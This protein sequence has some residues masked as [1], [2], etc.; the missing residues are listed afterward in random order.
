MVTSG[1]GLS[2]ARTQWGITRP[3]GHTRVGGGFFIHEVHYSEKAVSLKCLMVC[4]TVAL[5]HSP[6][7]L[8]PDHDWVESPS[9]G[10][11]GRTGPGRHQRSG[12]PTFWLSSWDMMKRPI[13]LCLKRRVDRS[14][15]LGAP[16][17][18]L[19]GRYWLYSLLSLPDS[20]C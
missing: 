7:I 19:V 1:G 6:V 18:N 15:A 10:V 17:T 14:G 5:A 3:G 20:R 12:M 8:P 2:G 11:R 13:R 4:A 16:P 9:P